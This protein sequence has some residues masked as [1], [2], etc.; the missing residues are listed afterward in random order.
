MADKVHLYQEDDQV[1]DQGRPKQYWF[2]CP[3][4]ENDH[5]FTVGGPHP[6]W[7]DARWTFNGSMDKPTFKPSLMC[8]RDD[9]K[10]RC[11]FFV[12]DGIIEFQQDCHHSLAGKK[13]EMLDWEGW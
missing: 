12:T 10:S 4:C 9:P 8:N 6:G 11:H 1:K 7:G 5:A 3:G 13:V 2:H